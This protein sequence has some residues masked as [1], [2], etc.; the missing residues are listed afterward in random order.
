MLAFHFAAHLLLPMRLALGDAYLF[1]DYATL[2]YHEFF[3]YN[4]NHQG[5]ALLS[6][7]SLFIFTERLVYWHPFDVHL[8]VGKIGGQSLGLC[9]YLLFDQ[10]STSLYPLFLDLQVFFD[11][12]GPPSRLLPREAAP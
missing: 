12:R 6:W 10:Q 3:F 5:V 8:F 4:R 1:A 9:L 2:G 11:E 7:P